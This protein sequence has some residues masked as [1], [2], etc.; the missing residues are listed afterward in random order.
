VK[1]PTSPD[2]D[3]T[4]IVRP[5]AEGVGMTKMELRDTTEPTAPALPDD[6][7]RWK[8]AGLGPNGKILDPTHLQ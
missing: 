1:I 3:F 8:N 7:A 6:N 2:K 5:M 4:I